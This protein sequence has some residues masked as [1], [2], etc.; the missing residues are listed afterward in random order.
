MSLTNDINR[1]LT[2]YPQELVKQ[3]RAAR[4]HL[5]GHFPR[6]FELVYDNYNALVFGFGPTE[7]ATDV[8]VSLAG[9]PRWVTLFFLK[10]AA[11]PDPAGILEGSGAQVRSVRLDPPGRLHE[12]AVQAL[13]AAAKASTNA[14]ATAPLRKTLIKSVSPVRRARRPPPKR[15][16][17][18]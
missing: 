8:V 12:P 16:S 1:F 9:Y 6:G 15:A 3:L 7:R 4:R 17:G 11:L 13:L 14:F 2:R 5:A 18:R 10:G